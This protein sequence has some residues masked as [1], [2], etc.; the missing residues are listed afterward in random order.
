[1]ITQ[2]LAVPSQVWPAGPEKRHP[3]ACVGTEVRVCQ[4]PC[5][6]ALGPCRRLAMDSVGGLRAGDWE[7]RNWIPVAPRGPATGRTQQ[8]ERV[9][10]LWLSPC[11][12]R[13]GE[14]NVTLGCWGCWRQ[15]RPFRRAI[16]QRRHES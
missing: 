2:K 7:S 6:A 3:S 11:R 10:S 13:Q 15:V 4:W 5:R 1:M 9:L 16:W 14:R 12:L 8:L